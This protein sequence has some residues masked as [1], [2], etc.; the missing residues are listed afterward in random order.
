MNV[1]P[2]TAQPHTVKIYTDNVVLW[3]PEYTLFSGRAVIGKLWGT[4]CR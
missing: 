2:T 3:L 1:Y 4:C